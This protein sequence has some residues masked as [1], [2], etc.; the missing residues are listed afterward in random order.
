MT[1]PLFSADALRAL[2]DIHVGTLTSRARIDQVRGATN[3]SGQGG[4]NVGGRA[5]ETVIDPDTGAPAV[6]V[7][8]RMAPLDPASDTT[9]ADQTVNITRW[10]VA[11]DF[12]GPTIIEGNRLTVSG[13]DVVQRPWSR[14]VV[15]IGAR[16]P[17]TY[18][19]MRI[20]ICQDAGPGMLGA[21]I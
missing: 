2:R 14:T 11:F 8:C 12:L 17:R 21:P 7:P 18:S 1:A 10:A 19:S 16:T 4:A 3:T 9:Q 6:D 13:V 5:W 15:V 20:F